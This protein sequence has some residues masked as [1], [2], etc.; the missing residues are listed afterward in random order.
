MRNEGEGECGQATQN[1]LQAVHHVPV[2]NR[3][4]LF[5]LF[6]PVRYVEVSKCFRPRCLESDL[7]S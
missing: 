6:V 1:L 4:R 5:F 3:A 2:Y 7:P